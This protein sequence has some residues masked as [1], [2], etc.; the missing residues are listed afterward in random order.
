MF[1][2]FD[3]RD[4][5][6]KVIDALDYI[7]DHLMKTYP[8]INF[9]IKKRMYNSNAVVIFIHDS[10]VFFTPQFQQWAFVDLQKEYLFP[11]NILNIILTFQQL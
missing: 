8:N 9:S 6:K 7:Y 4:L 2:D 3:T 11:K 1:T 5:P 10:E